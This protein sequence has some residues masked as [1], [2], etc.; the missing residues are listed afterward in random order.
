MWK[1]AFPSSR[2]LKY[3]IHIYAWGQSAYTTKPYTIPEL[4]GQSSSNL[5]M[6]DRAPSSHCRS[7]NYFWGQYLEWK[8]S[9]SLP[10][11]QL[12]PKTLVAV[13]NVG[14]VASPLGRDTNSPPNG[15]SPVT[16]LKRAS[17]SLIKAKG[18]N[19]MKWRNSHSINISIQWVVCWAH[20]GLKCIK[21]KMGILSLLSALLKKEETFFSNRI[22]SVNLS[23][24]LS[25]SVKLVHRE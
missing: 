10:E 24:Q 19:N 15:L 18:G 5:E 17:V 23:Q 22:I 1:Y 2:T 3:S 16:M 6:L 20:H 7:E 12:I 8:A 25:S 13:V 11:T 9:S 4:Q 21:L 14:G